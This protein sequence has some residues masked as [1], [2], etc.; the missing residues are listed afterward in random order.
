MHN[1]LNLFY[2]GTTLYMFQTVFPSIIRSLKP[3]IQHQVHVWHVLDA[4]CTILDSWRWTERPSE[5]CR[6]L[7]QN[8]INLRNCASGWL[9]YRNILRC[10]VL[11]TS[12]LK[13]LNL[14][15]FCVCSHVCVWVRVWIVTDDR[16]QTVSLWHLEIL[17]ESKIM[18]ETY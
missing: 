14:Y 11:Q 7:F 9:Y 8:K 13:K 6:V 1:I 16:V 4:V 5:T 17:D 12:N 18:W 3:Y 15:Q 10:T 2:F